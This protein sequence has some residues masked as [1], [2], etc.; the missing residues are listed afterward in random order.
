MP[1]LIKGGLPGIGGS[2]NC[3][4]RPRAL[5]VILLLMNY[6]G[7]DYKHD[8]KLDVVELF[9]GSAV[10]RTHGGCRDAWVTE[11]MNQKSEAIHWE[12]LLRGFAARKVD[13]EYSETNDMSKAWGFL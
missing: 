7:L 9:A 8:D 10:F 2:V 11:Q 6:M 5:I 3:W 4:P 1:V 13:L 12:A